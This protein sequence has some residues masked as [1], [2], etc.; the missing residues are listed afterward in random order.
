M[1]FRSYQTCLDRG[2]DGT[3]GVAIPRANAADLHLDPEVAQGI[4][5]GRFALWAPATLDELLELATGHT[6]GHVHGKVAQALDELH[7]AGK[8][9]RPRT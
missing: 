4:A 1:L 7:R 5:G 3:Q 9:A 8:G 6:A 2:L